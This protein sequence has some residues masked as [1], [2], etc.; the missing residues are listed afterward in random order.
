MTT[1]F[2]LGK[3]TPEAVTA[4]SAERS[5]QAGDIIK[6]CGGEVKEIY[7][8][9]GGVHDL[10]ILADFP[11]IKNAMQASVTMTRKT[12]IQFASCPAVTV[13]EFD[14]ICSA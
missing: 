9:L 10:V 14:R 12:N 7:A 5:R 1:F 2:L 6:D 3:Y 4:I 11:D 8:L 13:E